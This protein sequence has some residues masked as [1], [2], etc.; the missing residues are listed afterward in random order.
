[1]KTTPTLYLA[2][3]QAFSQ[4]NIEERLGDR[5]DKAPKIWEALENFTRQE[6]NHQFLRFSGNSLKTQNYVGLIQVQGFCIEILPKICGRDLRDH[7]PECQQQISKL[8]RAEF[9]DRVKEFIKP[10]TNLEP[11]QKPDCSLCYAKQVLYNCLATLKDTPFKQSQFSKLSS[12]HLPL[13]D[14]F[15]QMFLDA[16]AQLIKRGLK[17]DYLSIS[18]NRPYLKGKLEF[19][20]HL[21]YNIIHKERFYTI[22]DEYSLD[23]PP[24]RLIKSTLE[25]FKTL[26]L[27]PKSQEKLN[28]VRFVFDEVSPSKNID[29]DFA[30]SKHA[31]RFK[32]YENLLAW[33]D[34]FLRKKSL[35]PYKGVNRAYALLFSMERLFESFVGHWLQRSL[36]GCSVG[37]QKQNRKYLMLD[38]QNRKCFEMRP[39]IVLRKDGRIHILDTKWKTPENPRDI[40]PA[41]RYQMWAYASK[42]AFI[43]SESKSRQRCVG[44]WLVY[45]YQNRMEFAIYTFKANEGIELQIKYF[46]LG[47]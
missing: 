27:S 15:I 17:R 46:P 22:S 41:D 11:L 4:T 33:C 8:N 10:Q 32:E 6:G 20:H 30:K 24:N 39:D 5:K 7:A 21:K 42:Y 16:C 40:S 45:P 19:V 38:Q 37:L 9:Q 26:S 28:S 18:Q 47:N 25:M 35:T 14:V 12:A 3:Y 1:M 31:S 43:E 2:E 29:A 34:L 13:L 44:V 36:E 23:N